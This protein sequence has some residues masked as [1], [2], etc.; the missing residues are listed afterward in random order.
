MQST[1][2]LL[3]TYPIT[4]PRRGD[5]YIFQLFCRTF[6]TLFSLILIA[7]VP[8]RFTTCLCSVVL[9][10]TCQALHGFKMWPAFFITAFEWFYNQFYRTTMNLNTS[11]HSWW[12]FILIVITNN[13]TII[14]ATFSGRKVT[15]K[16]QRVQYLKMSVFKHCTLEKSYM[17]ELIRCGY[18]L[19]R[20]PLLTWVGRIHVMIV[21]KQ[22]DKIIS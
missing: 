4:K 2:P 5:R 16:K 21:E 19:P 1:E 20:I 3:S 13:T 22:R 6:G 9:F 11:C 15:V 8:L 12:W 14:F 7:G 10:R 18:Q 17:T